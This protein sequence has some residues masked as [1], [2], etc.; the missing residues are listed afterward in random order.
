MERNHAEWC[1]DQTFAVG[2]RK[3][4]DFNVID[5]YTMKTDDNRKMYFVKE[6]YTVEWEDYLPGQEHS[7]ISIVGLIYD[8]DKSWEMS[9]ESFEYVFDDHSDKIIHMM[10]SFSLK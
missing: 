5:S 8:Y 4:S 3:C 6:S 2:D 1:D 9:A 7:M 10:K